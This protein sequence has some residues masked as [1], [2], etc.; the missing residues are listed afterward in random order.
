M[1]VNQFRRM[2]CY[3]FNSNALDGPYIQAH[4]TRKVRKLLLFT[5]SCIVNGRLVAPN[6]STAIEASHNS[7]FTLFII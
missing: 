5:Y 7:C 6:S 1:F 4:I 2:S 3:H